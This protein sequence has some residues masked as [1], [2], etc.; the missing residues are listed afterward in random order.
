M[1]PI[2]T[3][4]MI[5]LLH[6]VLNCTAAL[7]LFRWTRIL[8]V[9][10]WFLVLFI[11]KETCWCWSYSLLLIGLFHEAICLTLCYLVHVFFSPFSNAITSLGEESFSCVCLIFACLILLVSSSPWCL[12]RAACFDCGT[13]WTFLYLLL[14]LTV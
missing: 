4:C 10:H 11:M 5:Y 1:K 6:V 9:L 8:F 3:F 14:M 2:F 7:S 13:P 12:G